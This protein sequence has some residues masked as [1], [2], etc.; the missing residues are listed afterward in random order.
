MA[1]RRRNQ[2][3]LT[4]VCGPHELQEGDYIVGH[5]VVNQ[6]VTKG[7]LAALRFGDKWKIVPWNERFSIHLED[8]GLET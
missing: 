7:G 2:K 8:T 6:A 3:P 4:M 5:G 1:T